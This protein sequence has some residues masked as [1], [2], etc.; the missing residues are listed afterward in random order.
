MLPR[1]IAL[2]LLSAFLLGAA[3]PADRERGDADWDVFGFGAPLPPAA[4]FAKTADERPFP[5]LPDEPSGQSVSLGTVTE[6]HIVGARPLPLPGRT[7][8]VLPRQ[9]QRHLLYGTDEIILAIIDASE[10]VDRVSPGAILWI[11]NIGRSG[12]GDIPWSVSHNSGRDADLA[13]YVTDPSGRPVA[14]PDLLHHADDGRSREYGGYYRFDTPRNWAL[15]KAL[16]LSPHAQMQHL[17][18]SD[19]LRRL[20]LDHARAIGEPA[21]LVEHAARVLRQPGAEIPHDDHLHVRVYCARADVGAGCENSGRVHPG[22]DLHSGVRAGRLRL[23]RTMAADANAETRAAAIRRLGALTEPTGE[24]VVRRALDDAV[25]GVRLAAVDALRNGDSERAVDWL[26]ERWDAETHP[27]VQERLLQT[28]A[29]HGGPA[30]GRLLEQVLREPLLVQR[31]ARRYDLRLA[32]ADAA[33]MARRAEPAY[34]LAALVG[35]EDPELSARALE[36]LAHITNRDPASLTGLALSD[37]RSPRVPVQGRQAAARAWEGW[38]ASNADDDR[39]GWTSAGYAEAGYALTGTARG[40]AAVLA[41]AAGDARP[42]VRVNAQRD[43]LA[44]TDN[45]ARS[46]EWSR[47]DARV[48]WTRWVRRNPHRIRAR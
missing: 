10:Y 41:R 44:L 6:G 28:L 42:W 40:D 1:S 43:L 33:R 19:G 26:I 21:A 45:P 34:R 38:L 48:Y 20:M 25:P 36:A 7:Y 9:L 37:W 3:P 15:V 16:L 2:V 23:A 22:V 29:L 30:V 18:V 31:G 14:P 24:Q 35:A 27:L 47:Q 11:G 17:F 46:L 32:A 12:G 5:F 8:S 39:A 13:F 4:T